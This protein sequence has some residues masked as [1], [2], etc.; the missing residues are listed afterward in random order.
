M[1]IAISYPPL[2]SYKG[3]PLLSQNRQFQ[4]FNAP[5]YIYPMIPA[6]AAT[7]LQKHGYEVVWDDAI[8]EQKP[9]LVWLEALKK[10]DIQLIAIESK[11]PTIK[12]Y[13]AI[14]N[15]IKMVRP[16]ITVILIGDHVTA[17]PEESLEKSNVDYVVTGGNFDLSLLSLADHISKKE[18]LCGGIY[19]RENGKIQNSGVFKQEGVLTHFPMINRDL[20]QWQHYSIYNGNYK[21]LPGTYTMIGRDCWWRKDGGC[22]FCSW[23]TIFPKF[24]MGSADQLLE[25]VD[26]LVHRYGV[27]EIFDDT[28]TFPGGKFLREFCEG[29]IRKGLHKKVVM[30]CN[31]KPGAL[32]QEQYDLMGKANF[33]FIFLKRSIKFY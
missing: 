29:L 23:T 19:Y 5:T 16:D 33:R 31:M 20:T 27:R 7:L 17:F 21:Y 6:Y 10:S 1:K 18:K 24:Q 26:M 12:K 3:T 25:E 28:G 8:A 2:E 32:D 13:W 11:T 9:Y 15:E 4:W 14:I 22:T 30:G